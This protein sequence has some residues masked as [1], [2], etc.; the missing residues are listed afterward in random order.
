MAGKDDSHRHSSSSISENV[1]VVETSYLTVTS[2]IILRSG[3]GL[4]SFNRDNS[5]DFSG[6]SKVR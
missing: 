6:D 3:E 1:A 4:T 2:F 5:V